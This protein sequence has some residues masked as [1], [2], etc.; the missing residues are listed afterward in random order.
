MQRLAKDNPM[1]Y[2]FYPGLSSNPQRVRDLRKHKDLNDITFSKFKHM[3]ARVGFRVESFRPCGTRLGRVVARVPIL[4]NSLLM[5]ILSS[6]AAAVL[7][8]IEATNGG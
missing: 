5:D 6:G 7:S 3:A 2:E 8:K 4:K 1:L